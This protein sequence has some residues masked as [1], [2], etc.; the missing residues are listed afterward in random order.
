[1]SI[2]DKDQVCKVNSMRSPVDGLPAIAHVTTLDGQDML[3]IADDAD[4]SHLAR[5]MFGDS[6]VILNG[7]ALILAW[8]PAEMDGIR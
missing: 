8:L 5:A 3:Y 4:L 7:D 1:M 2:F 6:S